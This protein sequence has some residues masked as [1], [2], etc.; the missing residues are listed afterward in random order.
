MVTVR[1]VAVT[2][3]LG[4]NIIS[5]GFTMSI[6]YPQ[7][8]EVTL[9]APVLAPTDSSKKPRSSWDLQLFDLHKDLRWKVMTV[10][11]W[12]LHKVWH[13]LVSGYTSPRGGTAEAGRWRDDTTDRGH[14]WAAKNPLKYLSKLIT[15]ACTKAKEKHINKT[16]LHW[17]QG[18]NYLMTD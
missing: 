10:L 17:S 6:F 3:D 13:Q 4:A 14:C 12:N 1:A 9:A 18:F 8:A 16:P 15:E 7:K 11:W 5:Q 2:G